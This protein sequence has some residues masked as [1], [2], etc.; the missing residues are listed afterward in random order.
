[1]I[2]SYGISIAGT[3]HDK[4]G[5]DC[6]DSN[7]ISKLSVC[8]IAAIADGVGSSKHSDIASSKA[9]EVA[10]DFCAEAVKK[11]TRD[12]D[13]AAIIKAAFR[14]AQNEIEEIAKQENNPY[15]DYDT[16][17]S[18]VIY[19]G[20]YITYG[21][22]GDGGIIGLTMSGDY[23]RV[24]MPQK[25][26]GIYV[27]PLRAGEDEWVFGHVQERV[28]SVLLAT[29]GIY[30]TFFPYLLKGQPIEVYVPLVRY[31]MDN[32]GLNVSQDTICEIEEE[33]IRFLKSEVCAAITDDKTVVVLIN[34]EVKP[35]LKKESFYAEPDWDTLKL[36][37]NKK[38]YPHLYKDGKE[39]EKD[40]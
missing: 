9:V 31:F 8:T 36:E 20:E 30:E 32:N 14:E 37:W 4:K 28:V 33:R 2:Y 1:M 7:K 10:V 38:A 11:S 39:K 19:N 27:I 26:E 22:C 16:T 25:K 35:S 17:L 12:D 3:S 40:A 23:V 21:H 24:T 5:I 6:Q 18:L 29:D 34:D 13:W 15:T